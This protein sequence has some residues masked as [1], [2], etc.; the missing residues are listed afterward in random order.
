MSVIV[1]FYPGLGD[2]VVVV[3]GGHGLIVGIGAMVGKED[4]PV[5]MGRGGDHVGFPDAFSHAPSQGTQSSPNVCPVLG[6]ML[7]CTP[8][9]VR[10]QSLHIGLLIACLLGWLAPSNVIGGEDVKEIF[11]MRGSGAVSGQA[12][13]V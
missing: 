6:N 12:R 9:P 13:L 7:N 3:A 8:E 10:P 5:G 4:L 11:D 1:A 2:V